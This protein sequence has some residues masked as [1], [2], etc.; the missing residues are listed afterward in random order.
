MVKKIPWL[1]NR[2]SI[3]FIES[4]P[5]QILI[6]RQLEGLELNVSQLACVNSRLSTFILTMCLDLSIYRHAPE[7]LGDSV[8]SDVGCF[9]KPRGILCLDLVPQFIADLS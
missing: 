7:P 1:S 3:F 4:C 5:Q 6:Q 8:G 9:A 2:L